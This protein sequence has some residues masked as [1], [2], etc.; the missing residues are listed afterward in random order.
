MEM[1]ELAERTGSFATPWR[2]APY[3]W[4]FFHDEGELLRQLQ[5]DWRTALAGAVYVAIDSGEGDLQEDVTTAFQRIRTR[6]AG[7]RAI[8]EANA[9][10]PAIAG[11][12]RK[13]RAL[14]SCV[15]AARSTA[16]SPTAA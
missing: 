12:M 7:T 15:V 4:E 16:E 11:A 3:V 6:Y 1:I 13:E 9:E 8:L 5:H 14:L 10:H 2:A